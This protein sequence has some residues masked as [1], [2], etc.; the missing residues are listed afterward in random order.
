MPK[1]TFVNENRTVDV[2]SGR[3]ISDVAAELGIAVCREEFAGTGI[4]DY[5]VWIKGPGGCVS[6]PGFWEKLS[7]IRGWRRLANKT[8]ILGD[9][10]IFTQAGLHDRLRAPRPVTAPPTPKTDPEARR[11]GVS[12]AGTAAFPGGNPQAVGKGTREAIARSTAKPKGAGAKGAAA[13]TEAA[14]DEESNE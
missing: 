8:K 10:E 4:G 2:E 3:K 1:V 11:L 14:E 5:T 6:P 9:V 12:S 13:A 7:G